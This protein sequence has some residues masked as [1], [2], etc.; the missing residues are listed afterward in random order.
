MIKRAPL[1]LLLVVL[2]SGCGDSPES[3]VAEMTRTYR[4]AK[5]F[6]VT[7]Q[8]TI[9]LRGVEQ[10]QEVQLVHRYAYAAPNRFAFETKIRGEV[11]QLVASDGKD[12]RALADEKR[13]V[14]DALAP[15]KLDGNTAALERFG[16]SLRNTPLAYVAGWNPLA[17]STATF[18]DAES[19]DGKPMHV[20]NLT[21]EAGP[22][23]LWIGKQ[24]H[25]LYQTRQA[26]DQRHNNFGVPV[27]TTE[28]FSGLQYDTALAD[29][30]FA[31]DVPKGARVLKVAVVGSPI[32][33]FKL[34]DLQGNSV[35]L[36]SLR[37]KV[38][39]LNFWAFW[40]GPCR[41]EL[42]ILR[43]M[44]EELKAKGVVFV[45]AT[46]PD[47]RDP[48]WTKTRDALAEAGVTYP[49]LID[50]GQLMA[51]AF[52]VEGLPHLAIIDRN[53]VLTANYTGVH[54]EQE[55]REA[56]EKAGA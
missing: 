56:L 12:V 21:A 53:G 55:I 16:F 22:I 27:T 14:L 51:I 52:G 35:E 50:E 19:L 38:V 23:T 18:G 8:E 31:V 48:K 17:D 30:E 43:A 47:E 54:P 28:R 7:S 41:M 1:L 13:S 15:P 46:S 11:A 5:S 6:S 20:V 29:S 45:G 33:N 2:C 9:R 44:S 10:S 34:K 24:D 49:C 3:V 25:L 39:V 26:V 42:P 40:C 36:A 32:P 37:G 4:G